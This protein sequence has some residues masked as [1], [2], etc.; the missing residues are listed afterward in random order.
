MDT[1]KPPARMESRDERITFRVSKA[2]REEA[3]A[4]AFREFGP[5]GLSRYV[6][7]CFFIGDSMKRAQ[8]RLK[9]T[10]V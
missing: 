8:S 9:A 7:D 6:R 5:A 3:E 2:E 1:R 10:A 4:S